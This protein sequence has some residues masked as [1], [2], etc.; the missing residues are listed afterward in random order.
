MFSSVNTIGLI[1]LSAYKINVEASITA[2][3]SG[4][5]IV[6]LPDT[7]VR[8]AKERVLSAIKNI[9][10]ELPYGK[11]TINLSPADT[12][13]EGAVFDLPIA[14][15]IL[16]SMEVISPINLSDYAFMGELSLN[17]KL[18]SV[19]GILPAVSSAKEFN[20]K[21]I[22]IPIDNSTEASIAQTASIFG[23][24][25]L[26]DVLKHICNKKQLPKTQS[27]ISD[28]FD[29][30]ENYDID[31]SDVKGQENVKRAFEIAAAGNHNILI[32]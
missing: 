6:G 8:E 2:G 18:N 29:C 3:L 31:F 25:H 28:L 27:S 16:S 10:F 14:I 17:G 24:K 11:I 1:G 9:G 19:N 4:C 21:N 7:A 32:L 23:A 15:A 26:D 13:K 22:I 20:I 30:S 12:K 5:D